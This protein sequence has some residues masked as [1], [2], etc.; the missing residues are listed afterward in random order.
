MSYCFFTTAAY[1]NLQN[2]ACYDGYRNFGVTTSSAGIIC[3]IGTTT[4]CCTPHF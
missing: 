3:C 2:I 4:T 1:Y